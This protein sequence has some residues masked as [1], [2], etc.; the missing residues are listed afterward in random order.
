M[1]MAKTKMSSATRGNPYGKT[2]APGKEAKPKTEDKPDD[3]EMSED[4]KGSLYDMLGRTTE[5]DMGYMAAH[6]GTGT[7]AAPERDLQA[8]PP[9]RP[10]MPN[11]DA[12]RA[13]ATQGLSGPP[14]TQGVRTGGPVPGAP[15][16]PPPPGMM[17][18]GPPPMAP[19]GAAP[20]P[21]PDPRLQQLYAQYGIR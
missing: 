7:R 2:G 18:P 21:M 16:M 4:E 14:A 6:R 8:A 1:A 10:N 19:P 12:L 20:R 17:P 9:P 3:S 15:P 13:R 11:L 5:R